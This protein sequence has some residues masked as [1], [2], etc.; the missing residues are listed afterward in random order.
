MRGHIKKR[1]SS[2][3]IVLSLGR[4][5]VTKQR[6]QQ[7]VTVHGTKKDA[8]RKL[9]ELL[10]QLDTGTFMKPGKTTLGEFLLKW[11]DEYAKPNLVPKTVEG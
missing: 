7:W 3:S 10:H 2:Y 11:L 4:D 9:A 5:P 6:K 1:K 8:E